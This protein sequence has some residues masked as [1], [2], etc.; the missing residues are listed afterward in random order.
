M[1]DVGVWQPSDAEEG[2]TAPRID[3]LRKAAANLDAP[4]FGLSAAE[5]RR[6]APSARLDFGVW[7]AAAESEASAELIA[8]LRFFTLAEARLPDFAAG[9]QSPVIPLARTLR[10]RGDYAPALTRWI[11]A[12]SANRFLPHGSLQERPQ[13]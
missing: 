8:W 12:N 5:L 4:A 13:R 11:K 3:L 2:A 9:A 1:S 7:E 6:L 10:R